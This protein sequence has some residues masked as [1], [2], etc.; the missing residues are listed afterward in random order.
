MAEVTGGP[1]HDVDG[2]A[3]VGPVG[4]GVAVPLQGARRATAAGS[5]LDGL[6]GSGLGL[7]AVQVGGHWPASASAI[8]AA[9][10]SPIPGRSCSRPRRASSSSRSV[11]AWPPRADARRKART[12]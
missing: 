2:A 3:A 10:V 11:P 12:R 4:V 1:G 5:R 7:Q 8:T 6:L 9:V